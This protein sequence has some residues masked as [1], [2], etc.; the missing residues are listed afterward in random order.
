MQLSKEIKILINSAFLTAKGY[1]NQYLTPEHV[2][3]SIFVS[4]NPILN[5]IGIDEEA[6]TTILIELE[7]FFESKVPKKDGVNPQESASFSNV[8]QRSV[9]ISE[10][11]D[12]D[13][14]DIGE[15]LV[16][17]HEEKESFGSFFM[18]KYGI[19]KNR[20]NQAAKKLVPA[21]G[22][23][24]NEKPESPL[25]AY[26]VELVQ[27]AKDGKIDPIIGRD[28]EIERTIQ[29]LCRKKKNNPIHV[30][31]PGVGKTALTEGLALRIAQEKV[32][33]ILR[34]YK[35]F[36]VDMGSMLAGTKF[37]GDFEE[38]MK[39]LIE[40][41]KNTE[42]SI[43]FIDE[44][45]TIIGAGTTGQ[46]ALDASNILK[47]A[48][49]SG[50]IRCIGS[51]TFEEYKKHF[52]KD[53]ALSRRFQKI[54]VNEPSLEDTKAIVL[55]IKEQYE[56]HHDVIYT[57]EA[58]EAIV[59][60][61]AQFINDKKLP[62]KAIDVLDEVGAK[63]RILNFGK[64]YKTNIVMDHHVE[65]IVSSIAKI[66]EKTVSTNEIDKLKN[67]ESSIKSF[68][69]GQDQAVESIV[70]A[71][72]RN[73]V[74]FQKKNKPVANLLFAG[75]TGVGKTF[76]AQKLADSMGIPLIRFDMSEYQEK[77]SVSRLIGTPP[78][79]V[80]FEEGGL[81]TDSIRKEPHSVLLLDEIEKAN[82]DI[83]NILLQVMDYAT[84]TDNNGRKAD[85]RNVII[86]MTSNAGAR[87]IGKNGIGFGALKQ[88]RDAV[89]N[90]VDKMFTPEFRNR[91]D[92]VVTF[93]DLDFDIVKNIVISEVE[94]FKNVLIEK[95]VSL[96]I[97]DEAIEWLTKHG[98]SDE[99]GARN[100]SRLIEDKIKEY[101]I[102]EILFGSLSEGGKSV[103]VVENDDI[104][105][106]SLN[107]S[108]DKS[109]VIGEGG[110]YEQIYG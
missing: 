90:A 100:I 34:D 83:F 47:P 2:L 1:K 109:L 108:I 101:F 96:S 97:S 98:Y 63:L 50:E 25:L 37:R 85:F 69:F 8:I 78:G 28:V 30:G 18:K 67:L 94:D 74:G 51:T 11:A 52:S 60:L 14:V 56:N 95:G 42:K 7:D 82:E 21:N 61:S 36:S 45:H 16:S 3:Y 49:T 39:M 110:K 19:T 4:S 20:I 31:D 103:A 104:V 15:I 80:G 91:L 88:G 5:L 68:V 76:V 86:I 9:L 92:K 55:G 77:H 26:A 13:T 107:L 6:R 79:Y 35:I 17:I 46:G 99:F 33:E 58:I 57:N 24:S 106:H 54:D 87:D 71:I 66:P 93:N 38:R 27:K 43:L 32:P 84:L 75:K 40:E 12:K 73:R 22:Q 65:E 41:A 48:L 72:K 10:N 105:I 70:R 29:I 64:E 89:Q 81:L 44:I 62:D 53:G 59:N 102:D 23:G